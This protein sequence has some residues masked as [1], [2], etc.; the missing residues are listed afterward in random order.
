M[1]YFIQPKGG[2]NIKIGTS[3]QLAGRLSQLA[4]E[5]GQELEVLA[6]VSGSFPIEK[7]MHRRFAHLRKVGE[8]FEPGSDLLAFIITDCQPWDGTDECPRNVRQISAQIDPELRDA[9][10]EFSRQRG[11]SIRHIIT[12]ALQDYLAANGYWPPKGKKNG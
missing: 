5:C 4:S 2:G 12:T 9:I 1:I 3:I 10:K 6:V 7:A 8:W 11:W